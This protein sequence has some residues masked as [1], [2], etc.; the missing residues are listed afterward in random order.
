MFYDES[1]ADPSRG[2]SDSS[3]KTG[4][5][6]VGS[7]HENSHDTLKSFCSLENSSKLRQNDEN[8][9]KMKPQKVFLFNSLLEHLEFVLLHTHIASAFLW[10]RNNRTQK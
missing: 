9:M 8:Q 7:L 4:A 2:C 3:S 1:S 5:E 6:S 10:T